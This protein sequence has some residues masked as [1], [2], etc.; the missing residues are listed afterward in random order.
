M[1]ASATYSYLFCLLL[2]I[3]LSISPL[4]ISQT[5]NSTDNKSSVQLCEI[6]GFSSSEISSIINRQEIQKQFDMISSIYIEIYQSK[7]F[8]SEQIY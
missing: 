2:L 7:L 6:T 3:S 4:E 8:Y 5:Y 1:K